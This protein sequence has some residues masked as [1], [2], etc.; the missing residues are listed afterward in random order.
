MN[1][2]LFIACLFIV[3]TSAQ[4]QREA[5]EL[6][7][8]DELRYGEVNGAKY[9]ELTGNVEIGKDSLSIT[10]EKAIYFPD[11][12]K[13]DFRE[14][15]IVNDG[16]RKMFASEVT[17]FDWLEEVH[18]KGGV[19]IYQDSIR[20]HCDRAVY[21]E[22]LG[23]GYL[24]D[25]VRVRYD[26]RDVTLTG[27]LGYF[28]HKSEAAWMTR[29]PVLIRRDS[30]G[31]AFTEIIG[32]T[33][34]YLDA[35]GL[36]TARGSVKIVRDSLTAFGDLLTFVTDSSYAVLTGKPL[37]VSS[38]DSILGDSMRLYFDGEAL[39]RVEVH[40][41]AIA[42]SPS[43]SLSSSPRQVLTGQSMTLWIEEGLLSRALI[44]G[45]ATANYFVR[46][47]QGDQGLNVTSG[48]RLAIRFSNRKISHI[49]VEGGT[50]GKYT[51]ESLVN[52]KFK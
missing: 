34:A 12:G 2:C 14:N 26:S 20:I 44:E 39:E 7:R 47:E 16:H 42:S 28:D 41:H 43:D 9:Q 35:E 24:Y 46:D 51:P 50:K 32:D 8:A 37:A 3:V 21:R 5:V 38:A 49:R 13:L 36:A 52:A 33:I 40:G 27:G 19:R 1:R 31:N 29:S 17:Y 25:N 4:G 23:N 45:T 30:T 6:R 48:D 18:A 15:V 22:R 10:C 11:S